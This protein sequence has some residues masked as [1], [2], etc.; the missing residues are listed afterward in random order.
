MPEPTARPRIV[1]LVKAGR[2]ARLAADAPHEFFYGYPELAAAG[3]D[4]RLVSD[5]AL[6]FDGRRRGVL[7]RG[8]NA[9]IYRLTGLPALAAWR[10]GASRNRLADADL[11]FVTTNTFGLGLGLLKRLG[12]LRSRVLFLAM[13]L[14]EPDTPSRWRAVFRWVLRDVT[15]V[16]LAEQDAR[17]L[18]EVLRRSL[19]YV[20]FGVDK[21]YWT[22]APQAEDGGYVL[23]IGNDRHRDFATLVAAWR[24]EFP[25]LKIV[26]HLPVHAYAANVEVIRGDWHSQ[27]L[28]DAEIR[29]LVRQARFVVLP[30]RNTVQPSGQSAALQAMACGK[31]VLV[32]DYPG[33]WNRETMVDGETCVLLGPPGD[34]EALA[35]T[36]ARVVATPGLVERVG[37]AARRVVEDRLNTE[38]M[39]ADLRT[40]MERSL[41]CALAGSS[42]RTE[43]A[44]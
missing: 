41:G 25:P 13:G 38:A 20:P 44:A 31:A 4:V 2:E 16:A 22:P 14:A 33:L 21:D 26:T 15:V 35:R 7:A 18:S 30:I 1:Y 23:S 39:A 10:L 6:G 37:T 43:G 32:T 17:L 34:A 28:S 5:A 9:L 36:V 19:P 24:P 40:Q 8:L 29:E 42:P 27:A 11:V 3:A 12:L